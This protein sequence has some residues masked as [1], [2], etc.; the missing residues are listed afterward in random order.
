MI[1]NRLL[2]DFSTFDER[3]IIECLTIVERLLSKC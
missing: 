2:N 1:V 3:L